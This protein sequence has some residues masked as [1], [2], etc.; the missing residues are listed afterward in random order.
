MVNTKVRQCRYL[1][2][3][4]QNYKKRHIDRNDSSRW[5]CH[6]K[7]RIC[8]ASWLQWKYLLIILERSEKIGSCRV[9]PIELYV[10]ILQYIH[11]IYEESRRY[12]T[13][14]T[15]CTKWLHEL[16]MNKQINLMSRNF[17]LLYNKMK[18]KNVE[19]EITPVSSIWYIDAIPPPI[20]MVSIPEEPIGIME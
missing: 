17:F 6:I 20:L 4:G 11:G 15:E 18:N 3:R 12:R 9:K 8:H 5:R 19:A 1:D 7:S 14:F 2:A 10:L 16:A 13:Y